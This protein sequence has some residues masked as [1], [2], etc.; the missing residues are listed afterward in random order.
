MSIENP[1]LLTQS[2]FVEQRTV[3]V[4]RP[5]DKRVV[6]L[7]SMRRHKGFVAAALKRG[8]SVPD[9]VLATYPDLKAVTR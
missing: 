3:T 4:H 1:H 7:M 8:E 2:Q 5:A 6:S 9:A